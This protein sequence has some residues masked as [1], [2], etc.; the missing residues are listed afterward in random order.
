MTRDEFNATRFSA[1]TV[2]SYED[3]NYDVV[4]LNFTE[5]LLGLD[6]YDDSSDLSWVRCESGEI[7]EAN[8]QCNRPQINATK[9]GSNDEQ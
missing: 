9:T 3:I 7:V 6:M 1:G 5:G 8:A 4:A 2:F